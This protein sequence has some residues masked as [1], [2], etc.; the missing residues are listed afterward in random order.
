MEIIANMVEA[1]I[2]R[3]SKNNIEFLLLKRSEGEIYPGIWQMVTGKFKTNEKAYETALR[4]IKEESGLCPLKMWVV[5]NVNSFY[6]HEHDSISMLPVFAALV[7]WNSEVKLSIE[8]SEFK[9]LFPEKAIKLLAWPGQ[10]K[11]VEFITNYYLKEIDFF[12][13]IEINLKG[14]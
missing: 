14:L 9:W 13:F 12:N 3:A 6:S 7:D 11:S 10:R 4:E 8:H 1:H 5:P 2:F